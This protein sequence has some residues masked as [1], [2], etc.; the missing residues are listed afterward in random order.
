MSLFF[1]TNMQADSFIKMVPLGFLIPVF[2]DLV[3]LCGR[4]ML[5]LLDVLVLSGFGL[6]AYAFLTAA[7]TGEVRIY[8]L[9]GGLCGALLYTQGVRKVLVYL[10]KKLLKQNIK[11]E[12]RAGIKKE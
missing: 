10:L 12:F 9:L 7:R 4:R 1:E 2:L 6:T 11:K 3:M 8:H 5:P